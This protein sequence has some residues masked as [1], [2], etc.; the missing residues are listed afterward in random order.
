MNWGW[1]GANNG[2]FTYNSYYINSST[3]YNND[4]IENIHG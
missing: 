3:N 4:V 1:E 2:W